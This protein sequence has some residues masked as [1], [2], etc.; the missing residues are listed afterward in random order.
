MTASSTGHVI[1]PERLS[2][3][4]CGIRQTHALYTDA[5]WRK[6]AEA[7]AGCFATDGEWRISG[8]VFRGREAIAQGITIILD[9]FI[10]VL[11]TARTPIVGIVDGA[12]T[13]RT[14][15]TEKCAW[16][17]GQ[18]NISIGRYYERFV[19][20]EGAWLFGWR[21]FELHYRG[22]PDMSGTFFEHRDYGPPP[23]MPPP[24]ATTQDM[25]S[26]RW[27]LPAGGTPG[28]DS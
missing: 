1:A 19:E 7:F 24:H 13:A 9:K 12:V 6:D 16:K 20:V 2:E 26:T 8:R 17:N 18:T 23:A 5:V 22:D 21:L 10:R 15:I 3:I 25:A 28:G 11:F 14:Y 4:E 27:G